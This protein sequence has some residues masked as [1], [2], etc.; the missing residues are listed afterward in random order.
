[1][2]ERPSEVDLRERKRTE[3]GAAGIGE[4]WDRVVDSDVRYGWVDD[5]RNGHY[6]A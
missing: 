4:A 2:P 3:Q 5:V 1:M 6:I